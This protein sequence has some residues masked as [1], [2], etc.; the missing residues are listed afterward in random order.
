MPRWLLREELVALSRTFRIPLGTFNCTA[1][2]QLRGAGGPSAPSLLAMNIGALVRT[3]PSTQPE[4]QRLHDWMYRQR[5][6]LG[7]LRALSQTGA[8]ARRLYPHFWKSE[9]FAETLARV[10]NSTASS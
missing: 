4:F 9:V 6:R 10:Q 7:D 2:L 5:S 1:W 3:A 8:D